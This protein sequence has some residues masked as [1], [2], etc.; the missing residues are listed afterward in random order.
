MG[1]SRAPALK[2]AAFLVASAL[3]WLG[4]L[5]PPLGGHLHAPTLSGITLVT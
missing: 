1:K 3:P 5:E 4:Q 2:A